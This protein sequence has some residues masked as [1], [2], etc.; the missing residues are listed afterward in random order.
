[1]LKEIG[2]H[3]F[4]QEPPTPNH[5]EFLSIIN[6][7]AQETTQTTPAQIKNEATLDSQFEP[8]E[9]LSSRKI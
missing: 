5:H 4:N 9:G 6:S 1:M 7:G 3:P 8:H 2:N